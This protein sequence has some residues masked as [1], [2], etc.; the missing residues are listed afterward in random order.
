MKSMK[1]LFGDTPAP[2]PSPHPSRAFD[3]VTYNASRDHDRLSGQLKA[4][5]DLMSDER[6][7]TLDEIQSMVKGTDASISA[8]LRDLRKTK[9]GGHEVERQHRVRGIWEYR[10]RVRG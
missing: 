9:Y 7:R 8:R 4:V 1:D 5:F 6:W 2:F 10:V 3:G